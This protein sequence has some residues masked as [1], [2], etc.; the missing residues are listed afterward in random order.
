VTRII[1][2]QMVAVAIAVSAQHPQGASEE[3]PLLHGGAQFGGFADRPTPAY[4]AAL[5]SMLHEAYVQTGRGTSSVER[6][7]A[8]VK[9]EF[10]KLTLRQKLEFATY[11]NRIESPPG[12]RWVR[13]IA[14]GDHS[15]REVVLSR[16]FAEEESNDFIATLVDVVHTLAA[17]IDL[18]ITEEFVKQ[19]RDRVSKLPPDLRVRAEREADEIVSSGN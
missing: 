12:A 1:P 16:M 5:D 15:G 14:E 17:V 2:I 6:I 9:R 10:N 13:V 3:V 18:R 7:P 8:G 4:V 19:L 11:R